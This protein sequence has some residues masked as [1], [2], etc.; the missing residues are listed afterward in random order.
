M[1]RV[2]TYSNVIIVACCRYRVN[3]TLS[4]RVSHLNT[5]W[6]HPEHSNSNRQYVSYSIRTHTSI[7]SLS[8][9]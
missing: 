8:D 4:S 1:K 5:P 9:L 3:T 6:N 7:M 2:A